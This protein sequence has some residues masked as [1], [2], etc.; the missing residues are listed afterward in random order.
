MEVRKL[1]SDWT[2]SALAR[3]QIAE[4]A[5]ATDLGGNSLA[6]LN[7]VNITSEQID[8]AECLI[9]AIRMEFK[10][11]VLIEVAFLTEYAQHLRLEPE[12]HVAA[13]LHARVRALEDRLRMPF[14]PRHHSPQSITEAVT[15][16][17]LIEA[18][19]GLRFDNRQFSVWLKPPE[20]GLNDRDG[21]W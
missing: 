7:S 14:R 5:T 13:A 6:L 21:S 10:P 4:L 20:D 17:P 19:N 9:Q 3:A 11:S 8:D 2:E 18:E 12:D 15:H 1:I 16:C